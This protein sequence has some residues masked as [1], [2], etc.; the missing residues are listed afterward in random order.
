MK[1]E[2]KQD[3]G[4]LKSVITRQ[5]GEWR[6]GLLELVQNACDA[7]RGMDNGEMLFLFDDE[8]SS[9]AIAD[10][11]RGMD[12]DDIE[13][14]FRTFG[15]SS[16]GDDDMGEFGMG[17]GQIITMC[18]DPKTDKMIGEVSVL[19]KTK[20]GKPY[21]I[22]NID[23]PSLTFEVSECTISEWYSLTNNRESGTAWILEKHEGH[24]WDAAA[25]KYYLE[26]KASYAPINIKFRYGETGTLYSINET[27][28]KDKCDIYIEEDEFI[29]AVGRQFDDLDFYERGIFVKTMS[30]SEIGGVVISKVAVKLN[31]ARN[32][33]LSDDPVWGGIKDRLDEE[34]AEFLRLAPLGE[35]AGVYAK[36]CAMLM[37]KGHE[38]LNDLQVFKDVIGKLWSLDQLKRKKKVYCDGRLADGHYQLKTGH[39]I[40][41]MNPALTT[42]LKET[43]GVEVGDR[44]DIGSE[45]H[46]TKPIV[47]H[48]YEKAIKFLEEF[49]DGRPIK[50]GRSKGASAFTDGH[51]IYFNYDK[52][53]H[54]FAVFTKSKIKFFAATVKTLAHELTHEDD[55]INDHH[56]DSWFWE[57]MLRKLQQLW[58]DFMK[59][60]YPNTTFMWESWR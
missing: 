57:Y 45:K 2:F 12:L 8:H 10:N 18:Y 14:Y 24:K 48:Y 21:K 30:R 47:G 9:F 19:T 56:H 32:D 43:E 25:V 26:A 40:M 29:I 53:S 37:L 55:T 33:P 1:Y 23:I 54:V 4:L 31:F 42:L 27:I 5:A 3:R 51:T 44:E 38:N 28:D 59:M 13:L 6:K 46:D 16:K 50:W 11:G 7:C 22:Y 49:T 60:Q 35:I 20:D 15:L 39:P 52:W 17:R 36:T 41:M 34:L 58:M